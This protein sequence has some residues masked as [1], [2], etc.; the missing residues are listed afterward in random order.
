MKGVI[1]VVVVVVVIVVDA[2][3]MTFE[4]ITGLG[5]VTFIVTKLLKLTDF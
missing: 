5:H 1:L 4:S 3:S 2:G